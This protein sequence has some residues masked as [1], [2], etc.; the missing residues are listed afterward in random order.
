MDAD[1]EFEYDEDPLTEEEVRFLDEMESAANAGLNFVN[2]YIYILVPIISF[3]KVYQT[4]PLH[5]LRPL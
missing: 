5:P 4:L 3:L 1:D 2:I